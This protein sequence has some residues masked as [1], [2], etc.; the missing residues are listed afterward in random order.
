MVRIGISVGV[1]LLL[2]I[3]CRLLAQ[4][5]EQGYAKLLKTLYKNTVPVIPPAL[6][7]QK[8]E[9]GVPVVL[10]DT[11]S[12]REYQVSHL[13]GA[14]LVPFDS[15]SAADVQAILR[16][17]EV[18]VYCSVGYRSERVGEKLQQ[19]G[20]TNVRNL[21]G[22]IFEWVNQGYPVYEGRK[23]TSRVHAY[24]RQWGIWLKQGEKVYE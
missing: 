17:S 13:P 21:Y 22:G 24:S 10:L 19:L 1:L 23:N 12:V 5:K 18:V 11:R 16:D 4:V 20:F 2:F 14:K 15:F 7:A 8:T 3:N 6:L 9:R